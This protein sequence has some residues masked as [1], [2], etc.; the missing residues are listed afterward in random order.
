MSNGVTVLNVC[1]DGASAMVGE[2]KGIAAWEM[3]ETMNDCIYIVNF[4]KARVLNSGIF[5]LLCEEIG[6]ELQPLL[7]Y[8][9]MADI[10]EY[11][12]ELKVKMQGE[13]ENILTCSDKLKGLKQKIK[14]RSLRIKFSEVP[15]DVFWISIE[16]EYKQISKAAIEVLLPFCTT[17][18]CE[19]KVDGELRVA[20]S[21]IEPNVQRL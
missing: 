17:Y 11:M 12:I 19:Q 15:L 1:S 6:S 20:L 7:Y 2:D 10:F 13:N 14:D 3:S 9:K 16:E 21:T 5:S 8:T 4:V 18:L